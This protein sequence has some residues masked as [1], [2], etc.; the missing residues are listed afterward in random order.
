MGSSY[1]EEYKKHFRPSEPTEDFEDRVLLYSVY[2]F[3]PDLK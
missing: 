1:I 3:S 2:G